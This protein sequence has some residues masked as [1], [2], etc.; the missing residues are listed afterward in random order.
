[1]HISNNNKLGALFNP[2]K[3][4]KKK[5]LQSIEQLVSINS[6]E[7]LIRIS[8]FQLISIGQASQFT[9]KYI[10]ISHPIKLFIQKHHKSVER[11]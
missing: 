4:K 9:V 5:V 7:K 6:M 1:M 3:D 10:I 2:N 8:S 11:I